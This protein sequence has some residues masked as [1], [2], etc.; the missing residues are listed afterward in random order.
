MKKLWLVDVDGT[1]LDKDLMWEQLEGIFHQSFPDVPVVNFRQYYDEH[2]GELHSVDVVR[3]LMEEKYGINE[4]AFKGM[5]DAVDYSACFDHEG[6]KRL[7]DR[8]ERE[9]TKLE[10]FTQGTR[11]VQEAKKRQIDKI[12]GELPW[13]MYEGDKIEELPDLVESCGERGITVCGLVDDMAINR[14][15]AEACG[16]ATAERL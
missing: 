4:A 5:F 10:F 7:T 14:I 12:V 15:R 9:G 3:V 2:K 11:W 6:W 8:A 13:H 16:L 1:V